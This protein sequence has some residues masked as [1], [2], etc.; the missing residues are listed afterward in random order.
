MSVITTNKLN[1]FWK[2]GIVPIK[3]AIEDIKQ[4][5][6]NELNKDDN[7]IL[8]TKKQINENVNPEYLAGALAVKELSNSVP[9]FIFGENGEI[10]GYKSPQGGGA[11][12][13]FPFKKEK[14]YTLVLTYDGVDQVYAGTS[15]CYILDEENKKVA[16]LVSVTPFMT[17]S[18][19]QIEITL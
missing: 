8:N 1:R 12:T 14:K 2:K 9:Q 10:I 5:S 13:V 3:K 19:R 17:S 7:K 18:S 6:G 4:A 15:T 11:D 16:Q